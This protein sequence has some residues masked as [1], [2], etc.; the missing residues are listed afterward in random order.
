MAKEKKGKKDK[1]GKKPE[2]SN[3]SNKKKKEGKGKGKGKNAF[4]KNYE[5]PESH[6]LDDVYELK[7][8]GAVDK[9][10]TSGKALVVEGQVIVDKKTKV[11]FKDY[12]NYENNN[13]TAV[14]LAHNTIED[15]CGILKCDQDLDEMVDALNDGPELYGKCKTQNNEYRSVQIQRYISPD[16][17]DED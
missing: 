11:K 1:K 16:D 4:D 5:P 15:L 12:I 17:V 13:E 8:T 7:I 14:A 6:N 9:K 10:T 3:K 2:K